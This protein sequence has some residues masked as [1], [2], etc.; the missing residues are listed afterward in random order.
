MRLGRTIRT[1]HRSTSTTDLLRALFHLI[2]ALSF[3]VPMWVFAIRFRD[4]WH[5]IDANGIPWLITASNGVIW[6][7]P[8]L[9][10]AY[11]WRQQALRPPGHD[12]TS[13]VRTYAYSQVVGVL[14]ALPLLLIFGSR[15]MRFFF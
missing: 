14:L 1:P 2:V 3:T 9:V 6:G 4:H 13:L 7:V 5:V 10:V 15:L 11:R 12:S 8:L